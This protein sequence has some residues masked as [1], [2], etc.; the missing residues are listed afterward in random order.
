VKLDLPW[1]AKWKENRDK[2]KSSGVVYLAPNS[3]TETWVA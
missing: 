2:A 1:W 3:Y